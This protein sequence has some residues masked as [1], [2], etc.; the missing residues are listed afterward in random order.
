MTIQCI[1]KMAAKHYS[2]NEVLHQIT[3]EKDL[4]EEFCFEGSDEVSDLEEEM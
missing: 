4:P 2:I 3:D 1:Q